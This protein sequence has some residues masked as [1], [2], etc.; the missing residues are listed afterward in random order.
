MD[1]RHD[2][3]QQA[4]AVGR[5]QAPRRRA[6]SRRRRTASPF[7]PL[8]N[9]ATRTAMPRRASHVPWGT[10]PSTAAPAERA[11]GGAEG[12]RTVHVSG[13][14]GVPQIVQ[15]RME[16]VPLDGLQGIANGRWS[17]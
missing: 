11:C 16:A 15:D 17:T 4:H 3:E 1:H 14:V 13:Q 2:F 10:G 12:V 6:R 7:F 9:C 5:G 8:V